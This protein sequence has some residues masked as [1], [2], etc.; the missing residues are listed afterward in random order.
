MMV[1]IEVSK[2]AVAEKTKEV[3]AEETVAK[4]QKADADAIKADCDAALAHV[5]PIYNS[6]IKAV[7]KLK[8]ADITEVKNFK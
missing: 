5:M 1:N 7:D 3:E 6:A 2:K 4:A 8:P